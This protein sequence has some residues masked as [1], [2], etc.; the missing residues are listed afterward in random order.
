[1]PG[2]S[3]SGSTL[4]ASLLLGFKRDDAARFSFLLSAPPIAGLYELKKRL[5]EL[6]AIG[7]APVLVGT[8]VA[9][10]VSYVSIVW[11][12]RWLR[13]RSLVPFAIYRMVLAAAL[14]GLLLTHTI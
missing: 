10:V 2:A 7:M 5:P 13:T 9:A 4:T 14:M 6:K 11:L 3:R 1:V 8:A 12:L